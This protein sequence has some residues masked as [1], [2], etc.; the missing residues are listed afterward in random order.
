MEAANGGNNF[1]DKKTCDQICTDPVGKDACMLPSVPGPCEGYY[2]RYAYNSKT[3]SCQS[4]NYGG[5]H[6]NNNRF[7]SNDECE[8][9][10]TEDDP[11]I[12]VYL[13]DK[14]SLPIKPGPCLGNFTRSDTLN[15]YAMTM[16]LLTFAK[17][18]SLLALI[19]NKSSTIATA[20][21]LDP[22]W[23]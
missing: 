19:R 3:K 10:C 20:R 17:T 18:H 1:D 22:V 15:S 11:D 9:V 2:P 8:A 23:I 5:C 6:G 16:F 13:V 12:A 4:F 21:F 14:C 7:E